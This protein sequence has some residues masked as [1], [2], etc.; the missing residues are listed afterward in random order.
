[1][2]LSQSLHNW[3]GT[4][5]KKRTQFSFAVGTTTSYQVDLTDIITFFIMILQTTWSSLVHGSRIDFPEHIGVKNI[6]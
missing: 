5:P 4:H 3:V 1:M 2:L 6:G